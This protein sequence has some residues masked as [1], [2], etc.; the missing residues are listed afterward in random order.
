MEIRNKFLIFVF[1][2]LKYSLM[3]N[4][5]YILVL[6]TFFLI[7]C[8]KEEIKPISQEI[9]EAGTTEEGILLYGKW[10]LIS[11]KMY[12]E[13]METGE[14]TVFDHFS[15]T[16]TTSSLRYS[17]AQ[18]EFETIKQNVTTWEFYAPPNW[19]GYG[20]FVL[21]GDTT[22]PYGLYILDEN[23]SVIEHPTATTS[24][25]QLG[26][27]SRPLQAVVTDYGSNQVAF[28]VQEAYEAIDGYNC[29]YYSELIFEKQ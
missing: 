18:F 6:S 1:N 14:K 9:E 5:I 21:D 16:K 19:Q 7:S 3:K 22:Q 13:N 29:N 2:Q 28:I 17:G 11:G 27:S 23:W 4:L 15:S 10:K 25:M 12:V 26:G 8:K 24:T 20:E